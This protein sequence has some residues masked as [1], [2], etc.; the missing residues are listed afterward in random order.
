MEPAKRFRIVTNQKEKKWVGRANQ[1]T[2]SDTN[3]E[4]FQKKLL[5]AMGLLSV[6][7]KGL[8]YL[9]HSPDEA[10]SIDQFHILPEKTMLLLRQTSNSISYQG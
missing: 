7:W 2:A 3:L 8:E 9:K 10:I 4:K 6:L 5:N 1:S